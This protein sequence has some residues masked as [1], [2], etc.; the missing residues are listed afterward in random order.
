MDRLADHALRDQLLHLA[1][2]RIAQGLGAADEG[3]LRCGHRIGELLGGLELAP[4]A[5][6]LLAVHV[7]ARLDRVR[8]MAGVPMVRRGDADHVDVRVGQQLAVVPVAPGKPELLLPSVDARPVDV[9]TSHQ[10]DRGTAIADPAHHVHVGAGTAAAT[11]E[12]D[13]Q[14]V[15]GA[16]GAGW[17]EARGGHGR[18]G[19]RHPAEEGP[20]GGAGGIEGRICIHGFQDVA[21]SGG[22]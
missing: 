1:P 5:H 6:R 12:A 15:V 22:Q 14:P 8:R 2:D 20:T 19:G 7:L 21:K 11:D 16:L 17:Q 4:M 3:D 18:A 10:I 9:A 13:A